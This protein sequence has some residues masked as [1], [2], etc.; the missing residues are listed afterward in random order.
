MTLT[1]Q[2]RALLDEA[3]GIVLDADDRMTAGL[4]HA[5]V[6]RL[7]ELLTACAENLA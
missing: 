7:A 4:A 2:G 6:R 3:D 5:D 1:E